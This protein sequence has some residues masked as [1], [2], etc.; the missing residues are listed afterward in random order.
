VGPFTVHDV[1]GKY[2]QRVQ[3]FKDGATKFL[4]YHASMLTPYLEEKSETRGRSFPFHLMDGGAAQPQP[5]ASE[6]R[7]VEGTPD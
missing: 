5:L 4:T 3:M 7:E 1:S 6:P 2:G